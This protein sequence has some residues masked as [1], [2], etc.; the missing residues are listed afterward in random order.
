MYGDVITQSEE[1]ILSHKIQEMHQLLI[2]HQF[3]TG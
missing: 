3:G 2:G 1:A